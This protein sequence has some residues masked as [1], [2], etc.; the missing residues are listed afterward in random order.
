[1]VVRDGEH[2]GKRTSGMV[3]IRDWWSM[4]IVGVV[5]GGH[6]GWWALGMVGVQGIF[7]SLGW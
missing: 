7:G 3:S 2:Q 4:G 6:P 1:M 5:D